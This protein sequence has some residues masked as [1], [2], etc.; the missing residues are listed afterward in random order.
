MTSNIQNFDLY[1]LGGSTES[2][3]YEEVDNE[4]MTTIIRRVVEHFVGLALDDEGDR[5][6]LIEALTEALS[7]A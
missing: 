2:N 7:V 5:E 6:T 1:D 4:A 3:M